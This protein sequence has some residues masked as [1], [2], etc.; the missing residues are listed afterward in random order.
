MLELGYFN[1]GNPGC[2]IVKSH[3]YGDQKSRNITLT[4]SKDLE[5]TVSENHDRKS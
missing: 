3:Y 1:L 2:F 5:M 4:E